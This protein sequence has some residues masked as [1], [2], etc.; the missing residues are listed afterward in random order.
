MNELNFPQ[1]TLENQELPSKDK[2][3]RFVKK[4][5]HTGYLS[6]YING[7]LGELVSHKDLISQEEQTALEQKF[8]TWD[9]DNQILGNL[10]LRLRSQFNTLKWLE[11]D[12][13]WQNPS[14]KKSLLSPEYISEKGEITFSNK[15]TERYATKI[16]QVMQDKTSLE[17]TFARRFKRQFSNEIDKGMLAVDEF[18][19]ISSTKAKPFRKNPNIRELQST[20]I[21][22]KVKEWNK[23]EL[24]SLFLLSWSYRNIQKY[25]EDNLNENYIDYLY[26]YWLYQD[27]V[28]SRKPIHY[29]Q[30]PSAIYLFLKF[31]KLYE[32]E[33][34]PLN[35]RWE[36]SPIPEYKEKVIQKLMQ[37]SGTLI[38]RKK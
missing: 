21:S 19:T 10:Y 32:K 14:S 23:I 36:I 22:K 6:V 30:D 38:K 13:I 35:E 7:V 4:C 1:Q 27:R 24:I 20:F 31:A 3:I 17:N 16:N 28:D 11:R 18:H 9:N 34:A 25:L 26:L 2:Q 8:S 15:T 33:I 12:W 29:S 37:N 5:L